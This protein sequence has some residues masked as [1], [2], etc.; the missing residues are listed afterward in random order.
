MRSY[1]KH[2]FV[3]ALILGA[4]QVVANLPMQ[5]RTIHL[6]G[7]I[8]HWQGESKFYSAGDPL[9]VA[10]GWPE[11]FYRRYSDVPAAEPFVWWSTSA[12]LRNVGV[13][14]GLVVCIG[15]LSFLVRRSHSKSTLGEKTEGKSH[16]DVETDQAKDGSST[17]ALSRWQ[18]INR[19]DIRFGI[20]DLLLATSLVALP[21]GFYQWHR[22]VSE[23]ELK[24]AKS[25]GP[26][27]SFQREAI[28]PAVFADWMPEFILG[29]SLKKVLLRTTKVRLNDPTD[30]LVVSTMSLP[31]LRSLA[32]GGG[33]YDLNGLAS[34]PN[35]VQMTALH[36]TGREL[37]D[38]TLTRIRQMD[39]LREIDFSRANVSHNTIEQLFQ[40]RHDAAARLL[41]IR[42]FDTAIDMTGLSNSQALSR[43]V[44]LHHLSL[45]RP[46]AGS[47]ADFR[48]PPMPSLRTLE[49]LSVDRGKNAS[50]FKIAIADC[51]VL[52]KL[53]I[54]LMQKC[55]LELSNLPKLKTITPYTFKTTLRLASKQTTPGALWIESIVVDKLPEFE[56]LTFYASD[57]RE[58]RFTETPRFN[59]LGP[60][61]F[62]HTPTTYSGE[63]RYD[64]QIPEEATLALVNGIAESD[65]PDLVDLAAVPIRGAKLGPLLANPRL[66]DL[67]LDRC[68]LQPADIESLLDHQSLRTVSMQGNDLGSLAIGQL[69]TRMPRLER[70][71]GDLYNVDRLRIED[72]KFLRGVVDRLPE[73][74]TPNRAHLAY[75]TAVRLIN[76][77]NWVD[78]IRLDAARF[79]HLTIQDLPKLKQLVIDGPVCKNA[80]L[81]GLKGLTG[82]AVGG[83][84]IDDSVIEDWSDC[85]QLSSIRLYNTSITAK[86]FRKLLDNKA[87]SQLDLRNA[88]INDDAFL[89]INPSALTSLSIHNTDLTEVSIRHALKSRVLQELNI[90]DIPISKDVAEEIIKLQ[91]LT[92]LGLNGAKLSGQQISRLGDLPWLDTLVISDVKL[93]SETAKVISSAGESRLKKLT[94]VD[95]QADGP[96]VASLMRRMPDMRLKLVRTE[97]PAMLESELFTKNRLIDSSQPDEMPFCR[98]PDGIKY[99]IFKSFV[100]GG[101]NGMFSG[102]TFGSMNSM[103]GN[104][105]FKP[106]SD[107]R[108]LKLTPEAFIDPDVDGMIPFSEVPE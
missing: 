23:S 91:E 107:D 30:Q 68:G 79:R 66:H 73:D 83:E 16:S 45:P 74:D 78:P 80:V 28:V 97:I 35:H 104:S 60:G 103:Y 33:D 101:G 3:V 21:L 72:H 12:L 20:G 11:T 51:P 76:L 13:G 40:Q 47:E 49:F 22:Q 81:S 18:R 105:S 8:Q 10:A 7:R 34:L 1:L 61:V 75:C 39:N 44:S 19:F 71:H 59:F 36:L 55:S 52:E 56:R 99:P 26:D 24:I 37:D 70:W 2:L 53:T 50:V 93:D 9:P 87:M 65:G 43:M 32:I 31:H 102:M 106:M 82:I 86:G 89:S 46:Q 25:L 95:S 62:Q 6:S 15:S 84:S 92:S 77:P 63:S 108:F 58:M 5:L 14:L 4:M 64:G 69:I 54:G 27:A 100:S 29:A 38:A 42:L 48:L 88:K 98:G 94:L 96:A 85:R 90:E 67:Y 41:L 17:P 57:L